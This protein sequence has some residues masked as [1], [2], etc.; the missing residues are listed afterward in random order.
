ME[1]GRVRMYIYTIFFAIALQISSNDY[2]KN[3]SSTVWI[4]NMK[5]QQ[6]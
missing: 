2:G 6:C 4:L 5:K 3:Q 1:N